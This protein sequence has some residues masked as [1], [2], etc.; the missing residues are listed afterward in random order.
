M[1]E[2]R[3]LSSREHE[4][5]SSFIPEIRRDETA[6]VLLAIRWAS[7][8]FEDVRAT[9][10]QYDKP[11]VRLPGGYGANRVAYEVVRQQGERLRRM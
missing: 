1:K 8:S 6:L 10:D 2:L 3:W 5:I 9:C 11:Y 4:S 7:H